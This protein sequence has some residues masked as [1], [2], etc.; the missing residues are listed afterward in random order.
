[1][2]NLLFT[3]TLITILFTGCKKDDPETETDPTPVYGTV[4]IEQKTYNTIKLDGLE[5]TIENYDGSQGVYYNGVVNHSYGKLLTLK[6]AKNIVLPSGW[7]RP[8]VTDYF[9]LIKKYGGFEN[10][11]TLPG[12]AIIDE[13]IKPSTINKLLSTTMWSIPGS[14]SSG[15]NA[16]PS[17]Y[18]GSNEQF[19]YSGVSTVLW[20]ST[21]YENN[22]IHYPILLGLSTD[23]G[24]HQGMFAEFAQV[25]L[26]PTEDTKGKGSIRFVRNIP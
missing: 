1:M 11:N 12:F 4:V 18:V 19:L 3:L 16:V 7:R 22:N 17:G 2:K 15:F 26:D 6:Q 9:Q 14:N 13:E 5:W 23:T 21:V 25:L 8:S 10:T 24:A 20:T